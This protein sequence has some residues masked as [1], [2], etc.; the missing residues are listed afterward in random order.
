MAAFAPLLSGDTVATE[1][2]LSAVKSNVEFLGTLA[3][4]GT[5]HLKGK[6]AVDV[7]SLATL[8]KWLAIDPPAALAGRGASMHG[9]VEAA[10]GPSA[11]PSA[12]AEVTA[13]GAPAPPAASVGPPATTTA[14]G[15]ADAWRIALRDAT[16]T[17]TGASPADE[18]R[19]SSLNGAV[20]AAGPGT[21]L[22][23]STDIVVNGE[24]IAV[25]AS[26]AELSALFSGRRLPAK[27]ALT[28]PRG[29]LTIEGTASADIAR[30]FV[31]TIA[32][33]ARASRA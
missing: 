6:V 19:V 14:P 2:K 31:G 10:W 28:A 5:R 11:T 17:L 12:T 15:S 8:C 18:I 29:K 21:P 9:A 33:E 24:Q 13:A 22:A 20:T 4:A 32:G 25:E 23:L 1:I 30:P 3:T 7:P 26:I 27:L 16:A